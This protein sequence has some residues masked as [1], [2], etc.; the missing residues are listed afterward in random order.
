MHKKQLWVVRYQGKKKGRKREEKGRKKRRKEE[1]K[2]KKRGGKREKK[3]EIGLEKRGIEV[4]KRENIFMTA[5]K[6]KKKGGRKFQGGGEFFWVAII[7]TP[8]IIF[9]SIHI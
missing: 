6:N 5:K 3:R 4:E 8:G 7:Y 9:T 1:E 2:E